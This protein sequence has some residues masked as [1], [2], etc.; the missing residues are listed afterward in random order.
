MS[1]KEE[2]ESRLQK[3]KVI[4][5]NFDS[6]LTEQDSNSLNEK[7]V[8]VFKNLFYFASNCI[9]TGKHFFE[10][11]DF[12]N[13]KPFEEIKESIL[14]YFNE[15]EQILD[16]KNE[17]SLKSK[18]QNGDGHTPETMPKTELF[19][20][21]STSFSN[22][23]MAIQLIVQNQEHLIKCAQ[24]YKNSEVNQNN[25]LDELINS[26]FI[27]KNLP[28]VYRN[29]IDF[30]VRIVIK[31]SLLEMVYRCENN[32]FEELI[33]IHFFLKNKNKI[34]DYKIN[35]EIIEL[36]TIKNSYLI[37]KI[38]NVDSLGSI[39]YK[40]LSAA[41]KPEEY[42]IKNDDFIE[43]KNSIS[44]FK[45]LKTENKNF[46]IDQ[47]YNKG[48][49]EYKSEK[50]FSSNEYLY[51]ARYFFMENDIPS[52][53]ILIKKL[54]IKTD[55]LREANSKNFSL[56]P[57]NLLIE[58]VK[59]FAIE[60]AL[61]NVELRSNL[62][63]FYNELFVKIKDGYNNSRHYLFQPYIIFINSLYD[64]IKEKIKT[65]SIIDHSEII[66]LENLLYKSINY[67]IQFQDKLNKGSFSRFRSDESSCCFEYTS[68]INN[69]HKKHSLFI[70]SGAESP[71]RVKHFNETVED[72]KMKMS[73]I[74]SITE[75]NQIINIEKEEI[76]VLRQQNE[77]NDRRHIEILG[78]FSA[79]ILAISASTQLFSNVRRIEDGI[80]LI[81]SVFF[82]LFLFFFMLFLIT[83]ENQIREIFK[84]LAFKILIATLILTAC[85][86]FY[87]M[88][89]W[90]Y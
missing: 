66:N 40:P 84:S 89:N 65:S 13:K 51:A 34:I 49:L 64:T 45:G 85:V 73:I 4:T 59:G 74:K 1:F 19:L 63:A 41:I 68:K 24:H 37:W 69:E 17:E 53:E 33:K 58:Y 9:V 87:M 30:Y 5:N 52:L 12:E 88:Q 82:I 25:D 60:C 15:I 61:K 80:I 23:Y 70:L 67:V 76:K 90:L 44:W 50:S 28:Q 75:I 22:L 8:D 55:K 39:D 14:N 43:L 71:F 78:I 57:L 29:H 26:D 42:Y 72:L 27:P 38:I 18:S 62:L 56:V 7:C 46:E 86:L 47:I 31:Q 32:I 2:I 81:T 36:F 79:I 35:Q 11:V 21:V 48:I 54:S 3:L 83:R 20:R 77:K 16:T 10:S 6:I